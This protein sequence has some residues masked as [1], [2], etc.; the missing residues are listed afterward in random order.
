MAT[1]YDAETAYTLSDG[2]QGSDVCDEAVLMA[3]QIAREDNRD[4][5][6]EDEN[7]LWFISAGTGKIREIDSDEARSLGFR[8]D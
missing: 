7:K 3:K 5:I 6:L 1:I 4:V 8:E 2:L